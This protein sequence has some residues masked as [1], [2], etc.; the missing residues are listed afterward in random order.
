MA[1]LIVGGLIAALAILAVKDSGTRKT[2]GWIG[3]I[4]LVPGLITVVS[5]GT[6]SFL[7]QNLDLGGQ[8]KVVTTPSGGVQQQTS[9]I[10]AVEDTTV[11]LSAVD[12]YTNTAAG[13]THKY[14]VNGNPALTVSDAS[15]LT[16]SPGDSLEILFQNESAGSNYFSEVQTQIVPCSGTVTFSTLLVQ[17]GTLTVEVFNEEGNLI[18]APENETIGS[19]DV[20]SLSGRLKGTYQRGYPY[21]GILVAEYN[22]TEY[23]DVILSTG[24]KTDTPS[25][26]TVSNTGNSVKA[27][28]V[29][30]ILSNQIVDFTITLD[31]STTDP[32]Y[33]DDPTLKFYPNNYYIDEDNGGLFVGPKTED[34]DDAQVAPMH[35]TTFTISVD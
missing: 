14:R 26:Y 8:T 7:D 18:S 21:G 27:Y 6:I 9:T 3:M 23:D 13:G 19:G 25:F 28:E 10:C 24:S 32:G 34:E 2:M 5:P 17:N 31:A 20:V 12:K 33:L 11:T 16:A 4:L 30:A 29:P 22:K 15:T 35:T 1:A